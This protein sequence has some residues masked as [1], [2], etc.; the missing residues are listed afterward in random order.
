MAKDDYDVLVF[1]I[2]TYLYRKL[3][4]GY[5]NETY[6]FPFTLELSTLINNQMCFFIDLSKS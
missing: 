6:L 2:L 4:N 3:K 1:K 5:E